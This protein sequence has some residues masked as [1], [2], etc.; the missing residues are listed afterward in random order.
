VLIHRQTDVRGI[1]AGYL[2]KSLYDLWLRFS[3]IG[4]HPE[5][6]VSPGDIRQAMRVP[7][8]PGELVFISFPNTAH[9]S[10][11]CYLPQCVGIILG[12]ALGATPLGIFYLARWF[13]LLFRVALGYWAVRTAPAIARPLVLILLMPMAV[14]IGST[15]SADGP[16]NAIAAAFAAFVCGIATRKEEKVSRK[17]LIILA[18][19]SLSVCLCKTAYAPLLGLLL[20]I[21]EKRL[22]GRAQYIAKIA[23][24]VAIC[25]AVAFYW[26][27]QSSSIGTQINMSSDVLARRQLDLFEQQPLHFAAILF[28]TTRRAGMEFFQSYVGVIGWHD[29]DV[30][31]EFVVAYLAVLLLACV[32]RDDV[33]D[34]PPFG[35][36]VIAVA[37]GVVISYFI[38]AFLTYLYW[39]PVGQA[40][41][42]GIQGRY[43]IP[44]SP[45]V[46]ILLVS[47]FGLIGFRVRSA[48][49]KI[50]LAI[51]IVAL[52]SCSI[53][54]G[55]VWNR[56]YG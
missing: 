54:F 27:F 38:I 20:I 11:M 51:G 52:C 10:P 46:A 56:Y 42:D 17:A 50:N 13:S 21:P 31:T 43:L 5:R 55:M 35:R 2:P 36:A 14:F 39:T 16:T 34:L 1:G 44:L 26:E 32:P 22:G 4:F 8:N 15:L 49:A 30:P 45:P 47:F 23:A 33:S 48:A 19:L 29:K 41:I 25:A 12:R 53:F 9:Y 7:L 6:K 3:H 37:P 40:T 28:E 18:A 24:L